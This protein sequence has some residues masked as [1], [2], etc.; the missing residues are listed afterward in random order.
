[1]VLVS[2]FSDDDLFHFHR[3]DHFYVLHDSLQVVVGGEPDIQLQGIF[4]NYKILWSN[5]IILSYDVA[6]ESVLKPWIN[7]NNLLMV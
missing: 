3:I 1:M 6:S 5:I 2:F 7:N 4:E